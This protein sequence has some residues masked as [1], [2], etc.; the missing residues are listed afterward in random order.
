M[1]PTFSFSLQSRHATSSYGG[2]HVHKNLLCDS[3]VGPSIST[4]TAR[5]LTETM[6]QGLRHKLPDF[7]VPR[8]VIVDCLPLNA[9]GKVDRQALLNAQGAQV[10]TWRKPRNPEEEA[11]SSIFAEVLGVRQVSID[12]DFFDL[13]G[14][15]LLAT[16]LT[17][18][19]ASVFGIEISIR[20]I[21]EAPTVEKFVDQ[22]KLARPAKPAVKPVPREQSSELSFAQQRLWFI[23]QLR[24][25]N[26]A[27]NSFEALR[28]RGNLD[29]N[30]LKAAFNEVIRRHEVLRT[31]FEQ[32]DGRPVQFVEPTVHL[33]VPVE[34]LR[35]L[36]SD[37][38]IPEAKRKASAEALKGF[39]LRQAPLLRVRLLQLGD[40]EYWC[41]VSVHHIATDA[42]S[43][44]ILARELSL[45]YESF[46]GGAK[47]TLPEITVQYRDYAA[48][49]RNFLQG[50]VMAA[51][52][53]YWRKQLKDLPLLDLPTD[54]PRSSHAG[55]EGAREDFILTPSLVKH[56]RDVCR[57]EGTT[58]F[59]LFL[60]AF[61]IV[62]RYWS[63]QDDVVV[64]TDVANRPVAEVE[65]LIGFFVNQL[66]LR[67]ELNGNLSFRE[68]VRRVRKICLD[69]YVYQDLPF[70]RLVE[71]INPDR[72]LQTSPLFQVKLAWKNLP[73]GELRL[74]NLTVE[75]V[76]IDEIPA[77]L[78]LTLSLTDHGEEIGGVLVY[79]KDLFDSTTIRRL[80]RHLTR[81]LEQ[82]V[83]DVNG[84]VHDLELLSEE[85]RLQVL[86]GWN[87]TSRP[88]P[89]STVVD[90]FEA[91]V[92]RRADAEA[93]VFGGKR[94]S[95]GELNRR[96]N[97]LAHYLR[98]LGVGPEVRVGICLERSL[99]MIIAVLGVLKAGGVYVP[100]DPEYPAERLGYM[101]EDAQVP[102]L[103]TE[104]GVAGKLPISWC[105]VL[106][107][108]QWDQLLQ[109]QADTNPERT[110]IAENAAYVIYTS[111]S[112][113]KPKGVVVTHGAVAN[114]L[115]WMQA[116]YELAADECVLQKTPFSFDVSVW[117]FFWPL[118]TG[119]RLVVARPGGHR[120]PAYLAE[121]I[122]QHHVTTTHFVPSMLQAFLEYANVAG[123]CKSLRRVFCG[124]EALSREL[125]AH[126]SRV[127]HN[128]QLHNRYGPTEAAIDVTYWEC[129][130]GEKKRVAIGR[131][132]WNTR[133]YVLD[134]R[135]KPVGIGVKG[136]LYIAGAGLARGYLKRAGLTGERFV[137][138]PYGG[139]GTR[140]YRTGD[141]VKW[142]GDGELEYVGRVDEQVKLRG[143]RIELGEVEAGLRSCAGVREAVVVVAGG[144]EEAGAGEKRLVGYVVGEAGAEVDGEEVREQLKRSL[145]EYM[146]PGVVGVLE[147]LPLTG[148]GKVDR[149]GLTEVKRWVEEKKKERRGPRTPE[150]EIL[151]GLFGEV[152]G[153]EEVGIDDNFFDLGG[154]SLLATR[155]ISR[156]AS[157]LGVEV[158]IGSLFEAPTVRG[159][160]ERLREGKAVGVKLGARARP[161]KI[162]LSYGQR[163]LWFLNRL[164]GPSGTYNIPIAV[165][166]MGRLDESALRLG[167]RDVV[168]RHESLRTRFAEE[169]GE[170][171]QEIVAIEEVDLEIAGE[172]V[173]TEAELRERMRGAAERGFELNREL[174]LRVHLFKLGAEEQ[175]LLLVLHHIAGDGWSMGP[176]AHD[177]GE[178]Y[179]ARC[180]GRAPGWKKLEVQYADYSLWQQEVLGEESERGSVLWEQMEYW[181][182]ELEGIG[183]EMELPRDRVRPA[184]ASYRGGSVGV[185]IDGRLHRE[186]GKLA[187]EG[188]ASLFMV[189]QA[190][191]AVW[192]TRLGAGTDLVMGSPIAGRRD[193]AVE[194][195]VGF[196]V[197]TLVL[198]VDTGGDASFREVLG[199]VRERD[200]KAYEHQD[201]PFER[202]VEALNPARSLGRHPLFQVMFAL[203]NTGEAKLELTGLRSRVERIESG[204]AKFDLS[205]SLGEVSRGEGIEAEGIEAEG[206]EGLVEYSGDIF[207][208]QTVERMTGWLV[209]V[210]EAV[211]RDPEIKIDE[212]ELLSEEE[213]RQVLEEW[214]QTSRAVPDQTVVDLFEAQVERSGAA[215]A[216]IFEQEQLSY[217]ELNRRSNRLAHDLR[218]MGVGAE[219]RV[220][221]A[222]ERSAE[223]VVAL[224]GVLK[225][226]AAYLPLDSEYP[227]ERLQFMLQDAEPAVVLTSRALAAKLPP[228]YKLIVLDEELTRKRLAECPVTNLTQPERLRPLL[229]QHPAYVI[230]TSGSTGKPKG[231]VVAHG[232]L[233][234]FLQ[235]MREECSLPQQHK[236]LAVTSL[237]FDIAALEI[238]MPLLS[239]ATVVL[240]SSSRVRDVRGLATVIRDLEVTSLQATPSLWQ[241]LI[242]TDPHS[243]SNV[244]VLVGGEPLSNT[245][246]ESLTRFGR[247]V[248]NLYG[249]TE[250]TIWSSLAGLKTSP[251]QKPSIGRPIWNTRLYVLDERLKPVGIGVKGE[252]YIA[253]AGLARGYLKR[254]GLTGERFVAD[255]YGGAGTRMYRTGDVVKWRGDGELEYVGRVDEQVKLRGYRIELGEVEAG[256]RSC[257]G[258]REAVVVV[259]GGE[260]EAGAGEKRL[261]GYVVGEAG[262]EVDGEEVREQLKR[263]LPEYMVPGVVGVLE[264]LPLT[265]NGKVDRKGLTEVKR[266]V[267]EKKKERRGPRTPEEEILCGLFGEV[268]GR[269]EVGIDDNFFD[270]GGHSLLATRLIS[271]IASTLG[272]EVTIGSLF[273]AP[274]VA[275]MSER[276]HVGTGPKPFETLLRLTSGKGGLPPLF[277][278]H[279][280]AGVGSVYSGLLQYIDSDHRPVYAIQ[281][282]PSSRGEWPTSVGEMAHEYVEQ[283][284]TIQPSGPY[285]LL[286]WSFGGLVAHEMACQIQELGEDIGTLV[287]LDAYPNS[288]QD[289][290]EEDD[291]DLSEV[292]SAVVRS[293]GYDVL[294]SGGLTHI[295]EVLR[296]DSRASIS[297]SP[298]QL[299][300]LLEAFRNNLRLTRSF[301]PARFRGDMLLFV[302]TDNSNGDPSNPALWRPFVSGTI[303]VHEVACRH[304]DMAKPGPLS[305]VGPALMVELESTRRSIDEAIF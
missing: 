223:M 174:P 70:E 141:V 234:N 34:D 181:R 167:L 116:E 305:Q 68:L 222:L 145:P 79:R 202:L 296:R 269:E 63:G 10:K 36:R 56:L 199:R 45:F 9:N 281:A 171:R 231:V 210:L 157:T 8:I 175:V 232:S 165:R 81:V 86:E 99:E 186:L 249:P 220:G 151:C 57:L 187:R 265:G 178:A 101:L 242:A 83:Q 270:L 142:R 268:L 148:N 192:L 18:R 185:R 262:A 44:D 107:V 155:L 111:G 259:A 138:D 143:Y 213:K 23:D 72:N 154:H 85:E 211:V 49:Q 32:V 104:D 177:L 294:H 136:E 253:G 275:T 276:L 80:S 91:Q 127:L 19:V 88:V 126:F 11:V 14:H 120:E 54:Y 84:R 216:V 250:T 37:A 236:L 293:L 243:F 196:F 160:G 102:V 297:L 110:V 97:R 203:Q 288:R 290:A 130:R 191:V 147:Q 50:D 244:A 251:R 302:A 209:R 43:M 226:G 225:S 41:L 219:D 122:Q 245:L 179:R 256:L 59:M 279:P 73:V 121:V 12:D 29:V 260:E 266:W 31:R 153:R 109:E 149:K 277:C 272:V 144:E 20:A 274:T 123:K 218:S 233:N 94:L 129:R 17:S 183:E 280:A 246:A 132:I 188:Q 240:A 228:G 6:L 124:G 299:S 152:L 271:R 2:D 76:E 22:L 42:W 217:G 162:P 24:P 137:A 52:L 140:M 35:S 168:E 180:E 204:I 258:V 112:T 78:D 206:I 131:P 301:A 69:A 60:A 87:Q 172:A 158:T 283:I 193:R 169:E 252:L 161:E 247:Q 190:A 96:S 200:L 61:Q 40:E 235:S 21:F 261:V 15:S 287:L 134:E 163:R 295:A 108:E 77:N 201:L 194:E 286:G 230:Y 282:S 285:N 58:L 176:L 46:V 229:P 205:I 4:E 197:N 224:L 55:A 33:E 300:D 53:Q 65:G 64:G 263:S 215:V 128:V 7:M 284:R 3:G 212:I 139:A 92:E 90:L 16:R 103:L 264:Q 159:I 38:V 189:L 135:L 146:V 5:S 257:A 30:A 115:M 289:T 71:D 66:V 239:G 255:P 170:P 89:E 100:L 150:E 291:L 237:G 195:M 74:A 304:Q 117:E 1:E 48:W 67:A 39:D 184:V 156:I 82:I 51:Q 106:C 248:T 198:R 208:R 75:R 182:K 26:G 254:A 267:E 118:M 214:N 98:S 13:G 241:L 278:V 298:G 93:V 95:Y 303:K 164:E 221:I 25:A 27:Y 273:E 173:K 47:P 62:L 133:L 113:G 166:L 292:A 119:A 207:E 28:L 227:Q 238:F 114:Q 125:Q 105:Q